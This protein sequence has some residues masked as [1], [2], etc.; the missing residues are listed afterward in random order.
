MKTKKLL[1][2]FVIVIVA[3]LMLTVALNSVQAVDA[4][5]K[6]VKVTW[7]GN[8]GKIGTAKTKV[9]SVKKNVKIGKLLKAPKRTGYEFKGWF[10]KKSGGKKITSTTKVKN[11]VTYHAQW[12]KK[13]DS[14]IDSKLIG[15]W[16][17]SYDGTYYYKVYLVQYFFLKDG[18][19]KFFDTR[20]GGYHLEA[21]YKTSNGKI[22]LT[23]FYYVYSA[24]GIPKTRHADKVVEYSVAKDDK[25]EYLR[26]GNIIGETDYS[27]IIETSSV[28]FRK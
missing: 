17:T 20:H 19:C 15:G 5:P 7:N 12:K 25:G 10:T 13:V 9:V 8:G 24:A 6:K 3:I 26:I 22:Y 16:S 1:S 21:K 27:K 11:K 28:K 14:D 2:L 18:T 4:T 23:D